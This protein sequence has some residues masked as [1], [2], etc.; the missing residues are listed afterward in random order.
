[1]THISIITLVNSP[2][3]YGNLYG[4]LNTRYYTL[5]QGFCFFWLFLM[6][7]K[8]LKYSSYLEHS[9]TLNRICWE[10]PNPPHFMCIC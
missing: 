4:A 6:E 9:G 2:Q 8:G 3:A 1:M 10:L 5:V 7:G